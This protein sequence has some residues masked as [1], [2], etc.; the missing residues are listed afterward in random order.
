MLRLFFVGLASGVLAAS[1]ACGGDG[2]DAPTATP[3]AS[4][5]EEG[6]RPQVSIEITARENAFSTDEIAVPAGAHVT[7]EFTSFDPAPH[8]FAVYATAGGG[9]DEVYVGETFTGPDET[10]SDDFVAPEEPGEY[11]FRCDVHPTTMVGRFIV[12]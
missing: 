11:F 7:V 4:V 3:R 10:V 2:G 5:L 9:E 8:N 12:E 1:V 6:E